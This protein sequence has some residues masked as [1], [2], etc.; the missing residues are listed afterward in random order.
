[1]IESFWSQAAALSVSNQSLGAV[2]RVEQTGQTLLLHDVNAALEITVVSENILRLRVAP[3]GTFLPD[4]SYGRKE[5]EFAALL[6]DWQET[7]EHYVLSLP[8]FALEIDRENMRTRIRTKDGLVL[9]EDEAGPNWEENTD[10]G[11]YY[12]HWQRRIAAGECFYGLGD[13]ASDLNLAGHRFVNWSTDAYAFERNTDPLYRNI[14]FYIGLVNGVAYGIFFDN[15]YR[16]HF[17]FGTDGSS[18][19]TYSAEGGELCCY[20]IHGPHMMDVVKRFSHLTGTHPMPPLWSLGYHQCRWSY[21]PEAK[22]KEIAAGFRDHQIPCD[23]VYLDIDYMDGYRCFTWDKEKFPEP[24]RMM[25]ELAED[26][27][28]TVV[29]LDPGIK[30]D[31]DYDVYKEGVENGYFCRRGDD[32]WME[33]PVWP[34]RCQFPDFTNPAVRSWWGD[35][36]AALL[37]EGVAGIW[38]DMNEP[39]VFGT[40]TFPTDVRHYYEGYRGSHRKAHNIYGMQMARA[41]Y[42]GL[43][44]YRPRRRPFVITR[45]TYAGGQRY[46]SCW[47]GDNIATWDHL[48]LANV[49]CQRMSMSGISFVGSDIGGFTGQPDG[50]LFTRWIQLGAFHPLMRGHSAGDTPSREPWSFGE[51]YTSICKKFIE[52]RYRL[53]PY[54]YSVFWENCRYGFPM[55]RPVV[56]M[57]QDDPTTTWRQDEFTLGDKILVCP[58]LDQGATSRT[59]YLPKGKW[60]YM[61]RHEIL[62]GG[63]ESHVEAP[64]DVMPIFVKAGTVLPLYPVQQYVGQIEI[65]EMMLHAY[66]SDYDANTFLYEDHGDTFAYEQDIYTEKHFAFRAGKKGFCIEQ[67]MEGYFT[68]R[69]DTY[70]IK[71]SGIPYDK[72]E[73][74]ADGQPVEVLTD[75]E[76]GIPAVRVFK[77]FTRLEVREKK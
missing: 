27:F 56:M 70:Y 53:L 39:S 1:M 45:S 46:A 47:T 3:H 8:D 73:I 42:E 40:G 69:Y 67:K 24:E 11:G 13:K 54:L 51:P 18:R 23:A 52:L 41:T 48:R 50:E 38:T 44:K 2:K 37:D 7:A 10:Y 32:Y 35:R 25:R 30:I 12:V 22:V 49:Q 58:V 76:E 65:K 61:G 66:Y 31:P 15:T 34:G 33:G 4:F 55:L 75:S 17:D 6:P 5:A 9:A 16:T 29:I 77:S 26:G 14:P 68:P 57:E 20:Y 63:Q 72:Y 60:Y 28:K 36:I 64:L 62:E 43:K 74:L 21:Y 59:V 71:F 19:L